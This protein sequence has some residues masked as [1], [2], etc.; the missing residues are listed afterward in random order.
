MTLTLLFGAYNNSARELNQPLWVI[1]NSSSTI[2]SSLTGNFTP[3]PSLDKILSISG[4]TSAA[5]NGT[6]TNYNNN[7]NTSGSLYFENSQVSIN[8]N[9]K[10]VPELRYWFH[11]WI[12]SASSGNTTPRANILSIDITFIVDS[13][14]INI[15]PMMQMSQGSADPR[16]NLF[17]RYCNWS[18][19]KI[20]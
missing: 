16:L 11:N 19:Q 7:I 9:T 5:A 1:L 17:A 2:P 6:P 3:S 4:T 10:P 15:Y 8:Q 12:T 20:N 14:S 18:F 13:G